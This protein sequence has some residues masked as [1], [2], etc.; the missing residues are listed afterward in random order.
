[1]LLV[2]GTTRLSG[3]R[4]AKERRWGGIETIIHADDPKVT[5]F[6]NREFRRRKMAKGLIKSGK[7]TSGHQATLELLG[8]EVTKVDGG[9]EVEVSEFVDELDLTKDPKGVLKA[10]VQGKKALTYGTKLQ[11]LV[12]KDDKDVVKE[13][14]GIFA[15]RQLSRMFEQDLS[16]LVMKDKAKV[17]AKKPAK[18]GSFLD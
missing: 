11:V 16:C 15:C 8:Y 7:K 1:M 4:K 9:I 12:K 6:P 3:G 17:K 2:C 5:V 18:L 14:S 10:V 13:F